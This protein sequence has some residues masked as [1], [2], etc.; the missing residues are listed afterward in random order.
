MRTPLFITIFCCVFLVSSDTQNAQCIECQEL[1][2]ADSLKAI[3]EQSVHKVMQPIMSELDSL[4]RL[5]VVLKAELDMLRNPKYRYK[6]DTLYYPQY[7]GCKVW[8]DVSVR[9]RR[10]VLIPRVGWEFDKAFTR[11]LN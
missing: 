8:Y 10:Y 6:Y 3:K 5:K 1:I 7:D 9:V 2:P 4:E 11:K